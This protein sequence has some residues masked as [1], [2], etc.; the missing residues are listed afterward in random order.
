MM[1]LPTRYDPK[2]HER[3]IYR[4]WEQSGGFQPREDVER[5]FT[6]MIPPP[7]V[8]GAL[9]MG[10]GLNGTI[11]DIV[12]RYRRMCGDAAL[13]L[14]GTDHAGIATQAV[15]EKKLYAEKK[16]KREE[17]GREAFLAEVWKWKEEYGSRILESSSSGAWAPR[18]T[19]RA[20]ASRW[21]RT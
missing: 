6:I 9:H 15:V 19:G 3:E 21:S 5:T 2:Q 17:M 12:I 11:Q 4:A 20:R 1:E 16:Q 10:H 14:P 13:W 18:A 8:T 7:N